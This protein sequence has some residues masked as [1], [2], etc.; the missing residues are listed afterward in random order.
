MPN[1]LV[2]W[3][4]KKTGD[5]TV[6]HSGRRYAC[7]AA[8]MN[9][10]ARA[11]GARVHFDVSRDG[12]S[13]LNVTALSGRRTRRG[14]GRFTNLAGAHSPWDKGGGVPA[15]ATLELRDVDRTHPMRL[16]RG[17][18]DAMARGGLDDALT[19]YA[20]NA[21]IHSGGE[22]ARGRGPMAS[23]LES[24]VCFGRE[25][26]ASSLHG[27]DADV[28]VEWAARPDMDVTVAR[29]RVAHGEIVEQWNDVEPTTSVGTI[30]EGTYP[31]QVALRGRVSQR[32]VDYCVDKVSRLDAHIDAPVLFVRVKLTQ[33]ADPAAHRPAIAEAVVDVNGEPV[34][35]HVAADKMMEAIDFLDE[36]LRDRLAHHRA[37]HGWTRPVEVTAQ[38]GEWRHG[39]LPTNRP[40]VFER[41]V[42]EREIV[43]RKSWEPDELT[44]DEAACDLES[45]DF[46][47]SLF[48]ELSTGQDS[49]IR[50][51]GDGT[52]E[53]LQVRPDPTAVE[54]AASSVT[55]SPVGVV[56]SS[57]DDAVERLN[58]IDDPFIAFVDGADGP[59]CVLYRRTDGNYGL[60][61]SSG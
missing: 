40:S 31:V 8:D 19:L 42:D 61:S 1:G 32:A 53:L 23:A 45:L 27:D 5:G 26:P 47:F 55:I 36:R 49:V 44:V 7:R 33:L 54:H 21:V 46:D 51:V 34:R 58:L 38:A 60:I 6:I 52:Y 22:D 48:R 2:Q 11:A 37:H 18:S 14:H 17:W 20:P 41:P 15:T 16:V 59:V 56:V 4:D 25:F 50:R 10:A 13:A 29:L 39:N 28:I 3:Y 43:R 24:M 57:V 35:A 12:T 9:A 30:G